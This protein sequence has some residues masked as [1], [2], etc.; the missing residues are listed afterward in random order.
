MTNYPALIVILPLIFAALAVLHVMTAINYQNAG[1]R[2]E[3]EK[4]LDDIADR[5]QEALNDLEF[6]AIKRKVDMIVATQSKKDCT[7][8]NTDDILKQS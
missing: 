5:R 2:K 7:P 4:I 6:Q 8:A 3:R 1:R